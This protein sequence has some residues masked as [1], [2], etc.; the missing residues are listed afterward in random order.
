MKIFLADKFEIFLGKQTL[1]LMA[2]EGTVDNALSLISAAAWY[3]SF[4]EFIFSSNSSIS[5]LVAE[6]RLS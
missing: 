6:N 4:S 5:A 1:S 3:F 2:T